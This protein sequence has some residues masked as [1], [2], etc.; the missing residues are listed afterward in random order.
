MKHSYYR[1]LNC[2]NLVINIT[3]KLIKII[4]YNKCL[5]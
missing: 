5:N 2:N 1:E 3:L 4:Q